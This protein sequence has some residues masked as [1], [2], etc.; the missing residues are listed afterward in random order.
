[1]VFSSISFIF[2]WKYLSQ[3]NLQLITVKLPLF[4][5]P[6]LLLVSIKRIKKNHTVLTHHSPLKFMNHILLEC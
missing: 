2:I 3:K 5:Y 4:I 6:L 1:M